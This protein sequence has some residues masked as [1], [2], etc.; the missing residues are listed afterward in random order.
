MECISFVA[1]TES[2]MIEMLADLY[3]SF[4]Y[5]KSEHIQREIE[6]AR[7]YATHHWVENENDIYRVSLYLES[8]HQQI[9]LSSN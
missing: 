2:K 7:V 6:W 3:D 1:F 4:F 5:R 9:W 8:N